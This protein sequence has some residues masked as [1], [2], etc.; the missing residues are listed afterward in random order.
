MCIRDRSEGAEYLTNY[1]K[2][3]EAG[4]AE[5]MAR[6]PG[7][8]VE[9]SSNRTSFRLERAAKQRML[10]RM[11]ESQGQVDPYHMP[12]KYNEGGSDGNYNQAFRNYRN[13]IGSFGV[14]FDKQ[15]NV[16][17][18]DVW[19]VDDPEEK[20]WLNKDEPADIAG[21]EGKRTGGY[22]NAADRLGTYREIP[23]EIRLTK[24]EW[25]ALGTGDEINPFLKSN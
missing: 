12:F 13:S 16:V 1:L 3:M 18:K 10:K 17:L 4:E 14:Y 23:I 8:S 11:Q 7:E 19:K 6:Y 9:D 21:Q 2:D 5:Y 25:E 22:W 24:E 20:S 15:G